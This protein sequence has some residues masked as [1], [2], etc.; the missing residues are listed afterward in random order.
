M[1]GKNYKI[2]LPATAGVIDLMRNIESIDGTPVTEQ[3]LLYIG[4]QLEIDRALASYGIMDNG[5]IHVVQRQLG[6][7][8]NA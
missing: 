4:L 8:F 2:S 7:V 1:T 6:A 3:R 5:T